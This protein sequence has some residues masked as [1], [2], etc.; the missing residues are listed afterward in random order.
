MIQF[1]SILVFLIAFVTLGISANATA[2][3]IDFRGKGTFVTSIWEL[4]D[5]GGRILQISGSDI[6][7]VSV[8]TGL[9]VVG[10]IDNTVLDS[11]ETISFEFD[12]YPSAVRKSVSNVQITIVR[13]D[14]EGD[15]TS[16]ISFESFDRGNNSLGQVAGPVTGTGTFASG[17]FSGVSKLDVTVTEGYIQIAAISFDVDTAQVVGIDIKPG[18]DPN[19][20]N[21]NGHGVIPVAILGSGEFDVAY[22]DQNSLSFGGLDVRVRGNKGPLCSLEDTNS[23][24]INDLVCHFEDNANYWEPGEDDA[25]LTGFLLDLTEIEGADSICVVP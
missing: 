18:S 25:T 6:L 19:C 24:G 12:K 17:G 20:F 16:T 1:K 5:S 7:L 2:E 4:S 9:G 14:L 8:A 13:N 10:G 21:I 11:G 22:I 3:T 23:D 15:Q